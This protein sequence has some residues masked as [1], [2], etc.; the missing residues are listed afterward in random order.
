MVVG[1]EARRLGVG[2]VV[3]RGGRQPPRRAIRQ[4]RH[5]EL[6]QARHEILERAGGAA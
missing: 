6:V 5:P 1:A 3:A 2:E 4:P